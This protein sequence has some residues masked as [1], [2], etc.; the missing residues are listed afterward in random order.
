MM[1]FLFFGLLCGF[2]SSAPLGPINLWLIHCVF[3]KFP[4]K[5]IW[6]FLSGV[7]LTDLSYAGVAAWGHSMVTIIKDSGHYLSMAGGFFLLILGLVNVSALRK[8]TRQGRFGSDVSTPGV[9]QKS[10]GFM[11]FIS[12]VILC[13]S[14]PAFLMFWLLVFQQLPEFMGSEIQLGSIFIFL[15]GV[16][17]GDGIWFYFMY[18]IAG[19]GK[20]HL[21]HRMIY[22]VRMLIGVTFV[23]C[24]TWF[25]WSGISSKLTG[26]P[27]SVGVVPGSA[28]S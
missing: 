5:R 12:G 14:N 19:I 8:S 23:I 1:L 11:D 24:G 17:L 13:G 26:D 28:A 27:V 21:G 22:G 3:E 16:G 7:I 2:C 10:S 4:K 18:K 25:I 6:C 15:A 9:V 20:D